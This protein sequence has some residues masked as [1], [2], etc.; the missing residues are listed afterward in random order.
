MAK[1][2]A[3]GAGCNFSPNH[4]ACTC[5]QWQWLIAICS[6]G[7]RQGSWLSVPKLQRPFQL[8]FL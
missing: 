3:G 5:S 1:L 2:A 4:K 7:H 8:E 6:D